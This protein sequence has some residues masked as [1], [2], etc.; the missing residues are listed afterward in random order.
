MGFLVAALS[1]YIAFGLAGRPGIAPGFIGGAVSVFVG[2][3]MLFDNERDYILNNSPQIY[4][5]LQRMFFPY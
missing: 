1:G 5:A 2:A 4:Y 3:G